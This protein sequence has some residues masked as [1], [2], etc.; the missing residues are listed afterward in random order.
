VRRFDR[1]R[2]HVGD[3][4]ILD[5]LRSDRLESNIYAVLDPARQPWAWRGGGRPLGRIRNVDWAVSLLRGPPLDR[6]ITDTAS[7][8]EW[9]PSLIRRLFTW[10]RTVAVLIPK[11]DAILVVECR[12]CAPSMTSISRGVSREPVELLRGVA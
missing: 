6:R 4:G 5:P 10:V 9:S 1:P 2:D 11:R 3:G 8:R 12:L 7:T